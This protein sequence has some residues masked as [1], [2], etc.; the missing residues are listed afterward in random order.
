MELTMGIWA[1]VE[2]NLTNNPESKFVMVDGDNRPIVEICVFQDV[3]KM[4]NDDW[5]QDEEKSGPVY[6]TIWK[7]KLGQ[8]VLEHFKTGARVVAEGDLHM[9]RYTDKEGVQQASLRMSS[10]DSVALL[11][12]RI[13]QIKFA[14]KRQREETPA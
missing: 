6:I 7:E 4:V 11:P 12:Y 1:R 5:V 10:V 2:G 9:H 8:G 14:P 3:S 13:D